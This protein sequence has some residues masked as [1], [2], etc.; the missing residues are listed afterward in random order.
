MKI[1]RINE[2]QIRCTLTSDDLTS[3]NLDLH[4]LAYGSENAR[5]LFREMIQTAASELDFDAEDIPLM[6]EAIPLPNNSI[7]LLITKIDDPE[8]LDTRFSRFSPDAEGGSGIS[9][10]DVPPEV[11]EGAG[12]LVNAIKKDLFGMPTP[13]DGAAIMPDGSRT[14]PASEAV[15]RIFRFANLDRVI[16][17]AEAEGDR[18]GCPNRLYKNPVTSE[19]YLV[20]ESAGT[21]L[22]AFNRL[23]NALTE[24]SEKTHQEAVS[25]AYFSE[26]YELITGERALQKLKNV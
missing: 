21:D 25:E 4:E 24:F 2:N 17:A 16:A 6:V 20:L 12:N 22:Q 1:E 9:W 19:Y 5:S 10:S 3:R 23:S 18:C 11:L 15:T 13:D 14:V 26:H 8:E 7:V